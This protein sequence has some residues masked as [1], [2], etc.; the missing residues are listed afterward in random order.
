MSASTAKMAEDAESRSGS[1]GAATFFRYEGAV[2]YAPLVVCGGFFVATI[3][4]FAFGPYEWHVSNAPTL[5]LFLGGSSLALVAGYL[6]AVRGAGAPSRRDSTGAFQNGR[7]EPVG[8]SEVA[9]SRRRALLRRLSSVRAA[10][11]VLDPSTLVIIASA[12]YLLLYLPTVRTTTGSWIPDLGTGLSN[13][14]EAYQTSKYYNLHGSQA[15]LYVRML[16]GPLLI[17]IFPVTLFSYARLSRSARVLGV[18][19]MVLTV[20]L[21]TWQGINKNVADLAGS[22]VMFLTIAYFS[23]ARGRATRRSGAAIVVVG[24]L[25]CGLFVTYYSGAVRSRGAMDQA[26]ASGAVSTP[27][28][29]EVPSP[30]DSPTAASSDVTP[31]PSAPPGSGPTASG[32]PL[33]AESQ[34]SVDDGIVGNATFGTA[35]VRPENPLYR[36]MPTRVRPTGMYLISYVTHGYKGLSLAMQHPFTPSYG[37]GF[38]EFVRHNVLRLNGQADSEAT[39]EANTY[40]GKIAA[41]GWEPGLMWSTFFVYPA[42]DITFFRTIVLM[43]GIGFVWLLSWR[44]AIERQDVLAIVVYFQLSILVFYL[45]ANNQMFQGGETTIGFVVVLFAWL[46]RRGGWRARRRAALGAR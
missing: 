1:I 14:G 29:S 44:D 32:T 45:S 27:G 24:V 13:A 16:F 10:V 7:S 38:S 12:V 2:R 5:Y 35:T 17:S 8:N 41:D 30:G 46:A 3:L 21:G 9:G 11:S 15:V 37:L 43:F 34:V 20:V 28:V 33:L 4:L 23:T 31:L 18:T 22:I 36:L 42:A 6:L 25:V 40:V 19:T 39:I 26:I